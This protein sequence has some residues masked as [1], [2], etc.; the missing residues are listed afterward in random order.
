MMGRGR[1]TNR[2]GDLSQFPTRLFYM[3]TQPRQ[4]TQKPK[5]S[6][7]R[8]HYPTDRLAFI[9]EPGTALPLPIGAPHHMDATWV[10]QSESPPMA[11][12]QAFTKQVSTWSQPRPLLASCHMGTTWVDQAGCQPP[13]SLTATACTHAHRP[14][15]STRQ[16]PLASNPVP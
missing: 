12:T 16:E 15:T 9:V 3:A 1:E 4:P 7:F 10:L 2:K 6:R 11:A 5:H 14:T 8:H 13:L